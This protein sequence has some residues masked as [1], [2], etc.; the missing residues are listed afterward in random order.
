MDLSND[1]S[2][3]IS[4]LFVDASGVERAFSAALALGY[5]ADEINLLLSEQTRQRLFAQG[6]VQSTLADKAAESTQYGASKEAA[7]LGGPAGGTAAT[8]APAAAAIGAAVLIPSLV[9]AGPIAIALAAAGA[10]GVAGGTLGAL[11]HWG[12]PKHHVENYEQQVRDGA[13]L[14]GVKPRSDDD[15]R[16]LREQWRAAGGTLLDA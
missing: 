14:I 10:V 13:I 3:M 4:A 16:Q 7:A 9:V 1:R 15:A 5:K 6:Q 11:T 12:I 2:G 8:L